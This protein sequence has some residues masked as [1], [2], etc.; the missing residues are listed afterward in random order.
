[1][2]LDVTLV[3]HGRRERTLDDQIG[4][5]E[6]GFHVALGDDLLLDE[7]G[8]RLGGLG[9]PLGEQVVV[10][11]RGARRHGREG[12]RHRI[13]HLVVHHH[14]RGGRFGGLVGR[15]RDRGHRMAMVE[16]LVA[17][18]QVVVEALAPPAHLRA[19]GEVGGSDYGKNAGHRF[20]GAG[21]DALDP[22]VRVRTADDFAEEHAGQGVVGAE[23]GTTGHLLQPVRSDGACADVLESCCGAHASFSSFPTRS[24][25]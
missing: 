15:R 1:M 4:S 9:E 20:R 21:V 5:R 8:G 7:V 10:Q 25:R 3:H 12:V 23:V 18:K 16:H 22:R 11:D 13:E 6:R 2:G 17:C 19:V 14:D 24:S